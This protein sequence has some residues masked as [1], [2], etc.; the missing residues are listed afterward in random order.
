MMKMTIITTLMDTRN[1]IQK[2]KGGTLRLRL[3]DEVIV[4]SQAPSLKDVR[5]VQNVT[6][7]EERKAR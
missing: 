1:A 5:A 3:W 4:P 6:L 2:E 7:T